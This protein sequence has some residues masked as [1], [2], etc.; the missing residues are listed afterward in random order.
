MKLLQGFQDRVDRFLWK[1]PNFGIRNL[2]LYIVIGN[3][4]IYLLSMMDRSS[5][6]VYYLVFSADRVLHGEIW[7]LISFVF[8]PRAGSILGLVLMLYFEYFIGRLLE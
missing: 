2:M 6:L 3:A 7:R 8:V 1:H 4:L 5:T